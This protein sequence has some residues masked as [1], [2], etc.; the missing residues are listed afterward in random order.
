MVTDAAPEITCVWSE[1]T[2][3]CSRASCSS[4]NPSRLAAGGRMGTIVVHQQLSNNL[5]NRSKVFL[6]VNS[7]ITNMNLRSIAFVLS[8]AVDLLGARASLGSP[9][10]SS[11]WFLLRFICSKPGDREKVII[12]EEPECRKQASAGG[13]SDMK[14][15]QA[16]N[17]AGALCCTL[18][19]FT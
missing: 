8:A 10:T 6:I 4:M 14:T 12:P 9:V 19:H 11:F 3:V 17:A 16:S 7:S 15:T 13:S 2:G 18:E 5:Y 1:C